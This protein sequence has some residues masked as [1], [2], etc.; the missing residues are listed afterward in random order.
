VSGPVRGHAVERRDS[1]RVATRIEAAYEDAERQIFLVS[2]DVSESGIFLL[3]PD[4]P[5][6]GGVARLTLE[7][8]GRAELLRVRGV[9]AR[10]QRG[11]PAGFAVRFEASSFSDAARA[12]LRRWLQETASPPAQ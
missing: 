4:P 7:L 8:P 3:A 5:A 11:E 10:S 6:A 9:V 12:S 1:P 2:R